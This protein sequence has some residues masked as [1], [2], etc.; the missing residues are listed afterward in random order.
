MIYVEPVN[1]WDK[2]MVGRRGIDPLGSHPS[3]S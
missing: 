1:L 2:F 3:L